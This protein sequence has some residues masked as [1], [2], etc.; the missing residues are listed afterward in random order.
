MNSNP[1]KSDL[2][3]Q[4]LNVDF[5]RYK[6]V[7]VTPFP[8][9]LIEMHEQFFSSDGAERKSFLSLEHRINLIFPFIFKNHLELKIA[10]RK[11]VIQVF[12]DFFG[13]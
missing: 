9:K 11:I 12:P 1:F 5:V 8:F 3:F 7:A 6:E 13:A 4:L 10:I 2:F